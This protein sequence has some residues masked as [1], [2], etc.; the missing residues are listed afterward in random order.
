MAATGATNR[1]IAQRLFVTQKTI[2][3]HLR[4]VFEK[5]N[6]SRREELPQ[7]PAAPGSAPEPRRD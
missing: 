2:E 6:I 4:H 3:T 1:D 7:E 5:L